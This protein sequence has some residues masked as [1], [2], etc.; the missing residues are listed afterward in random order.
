MDSFARYVPPLTIALEGFLISLSPR[1]LAIFI[2]MLMRNV[3]MA[4]MTNIHKVGIPII[5]MVFIY[6]MKCFQGASAE[7]A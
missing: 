5:G 6:V 2:I 4:F 7:I 1:A 3:S